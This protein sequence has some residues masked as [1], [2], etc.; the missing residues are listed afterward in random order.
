MRKLR[1]QRFLDGRPKWKSPSPQLVSAEDA[2][3]Y[4]QPQSRLPF[5]SPSAAPLSLTHT[6]RLPIKPPSASQHGQ[7]EARLGVSARLL[8]G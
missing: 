3:S 8:A 5:R 7:A 4:K 2:W 1:N 6:L